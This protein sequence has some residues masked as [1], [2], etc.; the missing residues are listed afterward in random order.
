[1]IR[2]IKKQAARSTIIDKSL[3][4]EK[5]DDLSRVKILL[6]GGAD[7]GKSTILKQMRILHMSGFSDEEMHSFHKHLRFNVFQ[8]FHEVAIGVQECIT[9]IAENEK[10][11]IYRFAE[12]LSWYMGLDDE[13]ENDILLSFLEMKCV[14]SFME[15]FPNYSSL[16]DNAHYY[17]PK[18]AT[19]LSPEYMPTS[20]D[21][22]HLRIPTTAV[23]EINFSFATSTIRL[24]DVGG[25]RTYRK[26]WI[27]CFDGVAAVLFVASMAAYDQALD[28]VDV[29]IKPVLHKDLLSPAHADKPKL[30][31]RLRD[32]AQLFGEMLRSTFLLAS[33]FILFLNKKDLFAKKLPVHPLNKYISGYTGRN[34]E[35]ASEYL[36]EYFLKRKSKKDKDRKIYSHYTC[37]TDTKNVEFVFKAACDIVLTKNL[38]S[39]GIQ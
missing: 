1:A 14:L 37:A 8:I 36:K 13:K 3:L 31:N 15:Q 21:I 10:H 23:N 22:L 38:N 16:P 19:L 28:E 34:T 39:S 5:N 7:A 35:Q 29:M 24:I 2:D 26:K 18:L 32:S 4:K 12:G 17:F 6:L 27:H 30:P 9:S 25:Q 11:L 20:E 33:A